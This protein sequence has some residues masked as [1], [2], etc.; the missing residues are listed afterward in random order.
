MKEDANSKTLGSI[1]ILKVIF[2]SCEYFEG[3]GGSLVCIGRVV[4]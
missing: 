3:Y 4:Y 1:V 2:V